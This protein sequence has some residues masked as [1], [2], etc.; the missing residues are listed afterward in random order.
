VRLDPF[1]VAMLAAIAVAAIAPGLGARGGTLHLD[2]VTQIG[3][4]LV[5]FLHGA[6]LSGAALR[7][8]AAN[9]R[10]HLLVQST[11]FFL[12]PLLFEESVAFEP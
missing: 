1:F 6:A 11:T 10:L 5:F 9:W 2:L 7:T 8:G 3:V 12:F 4:A